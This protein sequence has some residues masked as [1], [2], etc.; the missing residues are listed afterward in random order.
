[1]TDERLAPTLAA[2]IRTAACSFWVISTGFRDVV[3]CSMTKVGTVKLKSKMNKL[4]IA[5]D[6]FMIFSWMDQ[7]RAIW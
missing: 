2:W 5:I 7:R 3:D 4:T 6:R 1:M